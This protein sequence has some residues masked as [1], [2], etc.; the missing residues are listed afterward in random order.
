MRV[1]ALN[2]CTDLRTWALAV[3]VADRPQASVLSLV[4]EVLPAVVVLHRKTGNYLKV[5]ILSIA[6]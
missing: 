3:V 4:V 1:S 5:D 6:R 2:Y